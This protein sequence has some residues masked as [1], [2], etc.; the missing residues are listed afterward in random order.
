MFYQFIALFL[1]INRASAW[2]EI[3]GMEYIDPTVGYVNAY[4]EPKVCKIGRI[5]ANLETDG[6][7]PPG[8]GFVE[9]VGGQDIINSQWYTEE[10][11]FDT[12]TDGKHI[13][14]Q[15]NL[16]KSTQNFLEKTKFSLDRKREAWRR[17]V[18]AAAEKRKKKAETESIKKSFQKILDEQFEL[19]KEKLHDEYVKKE[20][21]V[22]VKMDE[23]VSVNVEIGLS[24]NKKFDIDEFDP[25]QSLEPLFSDIV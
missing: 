9:C 20:S 12:D 22:S 2:Y 1:L 11:N 21:E 10:P 7:V 24:N 19:F 4:Y 17:E 14:L 8:I 3:W 25:D 5:N 18:A 23:N 13:H 15:V 6:N 16:L